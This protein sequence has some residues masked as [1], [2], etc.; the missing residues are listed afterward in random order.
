MNGTADYY[1][2]LSPE[3]RNELIWSRDTCDLCHAPFFSPEDRVI[4][5][6]HDTG[7]VRGIVHPACNTRI[8]SWTARTY[9][10]LAAYLT[11]SDEWQMIFRAA[12]REWGVRKDG[13]VFTRL[14]YPPKENSETA[15]NGSIVEGEKEE[16]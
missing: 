7:L 11:G 3:R 13:R 14:L 12:N 9:G 5:H 16:P 2:G 1:E 8:G 4:D 15:I 6:D 10:Y